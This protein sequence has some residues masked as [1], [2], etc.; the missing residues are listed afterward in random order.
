MK[1]PRR[2][3]LRLAAG[4]AGLASVAIS[5]IAVTGSAAWSQTSRTVKVV[6]PFTAGGVADT[7]A[8]LLVEQIVRTQGPMV[9]IENR[10]G[11]GSVIGTEAVARATPDGNTVLLTS[12]SFA[13]NPQ[14]RKVNYDALTSFEPICYLTRIQSVIAVNSASPYRTLADLINA[15]RAKP[16]DVTL[17][18]TQGG[19]GQMAFEMLKRA[20]SVNMT[21]VAYP[22]DAPAVN[23]LLGEHVTSV[24]FTY[25]AVAA[26]V[27]AGKLR[28]L[29]IASQERTKPLPEVLTIAE[30]GYKDIDADTWYGVFAPARTPKETLAQLAG[31][32]GTAVQS[33]EIKPKLAVLGHDP[34]GMCGA[35]FGAFL[36]KRYDDYGRIVRETNIKVE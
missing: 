15:A 18:A 26:Q 29:A 8:R 21:F 36:R 1:F 22:G 34:V 9:V 3:F 14:L 19:I 30:S 4:A 17:A 35:D 7:L 33:S 2:R 11:A 20:A 23:A 27:S 5:V 6:V 32:F 25:A 10:A 31:W 12:T 13:T 24:L 16:G 28:V